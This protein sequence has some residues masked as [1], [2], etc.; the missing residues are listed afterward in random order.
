MDKIV[1][2]LDNEQREC[3]VC[4]FTEARP[5]HTPASSTTGAAVTAREVPTRVTRAA[6]RRLDT[7]PEPVRIVDPPK[8]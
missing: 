4:G 5:V 8:K 7:P 2:D 3:V 6:A 1:V